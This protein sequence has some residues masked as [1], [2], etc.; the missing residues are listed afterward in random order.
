MF[1]QH[2]DLVTIATT[3]GADIHASL[4]GQ[5]ELLAILQAWTSGLSRGKDHDS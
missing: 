5:A 3:T 2:R 1:E 4:A